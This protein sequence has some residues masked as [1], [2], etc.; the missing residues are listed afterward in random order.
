M[1]I[2]LPHV[3]KRQA[4]YAKPITLHN[5][6]NEGETKGRKEEEGE[7]EVGVRE[8]VNSREP[9]R[10]KEVGKDAAR[11]VVRGCK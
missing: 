8:D 4:L 1:M 2:A 5:G 10:E 11:P 7:R 3:L 9:G 6:R